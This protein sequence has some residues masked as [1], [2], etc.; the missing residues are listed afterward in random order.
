MVS[1]KE[2]IQIK[3]TSHWSTE[4]HEDANFFFFSLNNIKSFSLGKGDF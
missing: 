3:C 1:F 2:E 4:N